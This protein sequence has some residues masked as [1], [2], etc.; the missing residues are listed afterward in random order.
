MKTTKRVSYLKSCLN[1]QKTKNQKIK[2]SMF[3]KKV[4]TLITIIY[5]LIWPTNSLIKK[6]LVEQMSNLSPN[7]KKEIEDYL[8]PIPSRYEKHKNRELVKVINYLQLKNFTEI[9]NSTLKYETQLELFN[10]LSS[11]DKTIHKNFSDVKIIYL[12]ES[13]KF[14]NSMILLN[15]LIAYCEDLDIKI[16]YLNIDMNWPIVDDIFTDRIN[17]YFVSPYQIDCEDKAILCADYKPFF[18][19]T[20]VKPEIRISL[21]KDEVKRNL[22]S[23]NTDRN[24]LYIHIRSGDIFKRRPNTHYAQPPLCFYQKIINNFYF[25]NI[26]IVSENRKNPII[27]LLTKEFHE[28]IFIDNYIETDAAILSNAYNIVGSMSSF[29]TTLVMIND[30][31]INYWDFD[32]YRLSEKYLHFHHDIYNLNMNYTLYE[33][34]PSE[35]YRKEMFVWRNSKRQVDLMINE[36]CREFNVIKPH[37]LL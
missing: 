3:L 13:L 22:P 32:N 36:K 5:F 28:I 26:Y 21:F 16:I 6:Q 37:E 10:Q 14:G 23:I 11:F 8:L 27:D 20:V 1:N 24:D 33:M 25:K 7:L 18:Y 30:N 29:L 2:I 12:Q 19:L 9:T 35:D 17:I 15:N 31:L 4:M 34:K